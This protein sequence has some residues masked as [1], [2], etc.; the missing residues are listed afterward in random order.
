MAAR[1][2]KSKYEVDPTPESRRGRPNKECVAMAEMVEDWA[3]VPAGVNV[4]LPDTK[5]LASDA[6]RAEIASAREGARHHFRKYA[7]PAGLVIKRD[8]R[9]VYNSVSNRINVVK[10]AD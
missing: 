7:E 3:N 4:Y 2:A 8:Y 5:E 9:I 6:T 1:K 10:L